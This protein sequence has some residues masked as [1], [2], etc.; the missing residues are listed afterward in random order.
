MANSLNRNLKVGDQLILSNGAQVAVVEPLM[1]GAMSFTS[2]AALAVSGYGRISGYDIDA[3]ATL[4]RFGAANG[5][6]KEK[7]HD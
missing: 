7:A 5:W 2:G 6:D 1:F 3:K 4:A